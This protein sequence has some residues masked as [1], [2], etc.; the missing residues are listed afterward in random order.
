MRT[1]QIVEKLNTVPQ[2]AGRLEIIATKPTVLRDYA[3]TPDA[4]ER[5]LH[6]TRA[7]TRGRLIVVFGAGGDRDRGKRPIMGQI[8]E[9][10]ADY[11][12]VTS[13]NPRTEDADSIIDDIEA[14]MRLS[15]HERVTDRLSA[16][17]RALE[18]AKPDDIV[19]LAGKGHET[20]QVRGTTSYAFDEKKI[21]EELTGGG[22][23]EAGSGRA[24]T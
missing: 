20:Y 21:V 18:T 3:H 7:F 16:I 22:K 24:R 12:I 6:T 5:S 15:N 8:A 2:V 4:L 17:K 23:R 13:D 19:L 9:R 11:A 10:R 14:G 1:P